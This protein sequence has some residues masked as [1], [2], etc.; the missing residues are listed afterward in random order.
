MAS[1]TRVTGGT[2]FVLVSTEWQ[3]R[4]VSTRCLST[5]WRQS[6]GPLCSGRQ[7]RTARSLRT[8][9]NPSAWGTAGPWRLWHK[10]AKRHVPSANPGQ[11]IVKHLKQPSWLVF[12][13]FASCPSRSRCC[14]I[15]CSWR[16]SPRRTVNDRASS[17][18]LKYRAGF[19][20]VRPTGCTKGGTDPG[21]KWAHCSL[22]LNWLGRDRL[23]AVPTRGRPS[24]LKLR[25]LEVVAIHCL[26]SQPEAS[27]YLQSSDRYT[28]HLALLFC[29]SQCWT[30]KSAVHKWH[31]S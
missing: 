3:R 2:L 9:H 20:A 26:S 11:F 22:F 5:I 16:R 10:W 23:L 17:S 21:S 14:C 8:P 25:G 1:S 19:E 30:F 7:R 13:V 12:P 27:S 24:S 29:S 6:S 31:W 4:N 28:C 15:S 18:P